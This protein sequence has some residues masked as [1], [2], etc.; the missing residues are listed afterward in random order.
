M[1]RFLIFMVIALILAY[2]D[3][4]LIWGFLIGLGYS[5]ICGIIDDRKD[6]GDC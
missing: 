5:E 1:I 3:A 2:A 4:K 6:R